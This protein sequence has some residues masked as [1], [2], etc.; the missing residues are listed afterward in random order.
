MP[1][2]TISA[3]CP[4][5]MQ[6]HKHVTRPGEDTEERDRSEE[7]ERWNPKQTDT[8]WIC[9]LTVAWIIH[10]VAETGRPW[11]DAAAGSA[12]HGCRGVRGAVAF[13]WHR[14]G[15]RHAIFVMEMRGVRGIHLV[16]RSWRG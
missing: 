15:D 2:S 4:K 7:L 6:G 1:S 13:R 8:R 11:S 9:I 10:A 14:H 16:A 12:G 5:V 3:I